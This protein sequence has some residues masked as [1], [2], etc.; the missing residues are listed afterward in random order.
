MWHKTSAAMLA[1]AS[2]CV[3]GLTACGSSSSASSEAKKQPADILADAKSALFNAKS[4]HATG[5]T[6]DS[7]TT[8]MLDFSFVGQDTSGTLTSNNVK[9]QIVKAGGTI[10]VNAPA[11]FWSKTAPTQASV[12]AG[13]WIIVPADQD[14]DFSDFTLQGI[15]ASLNSD[16]SPLQPDVKKTTVNGTKALVISQQDGSTLTVE[17]DSTPRPLKLTD[18]SSHGDV[19]FSDY[20]KVR[21]I[22]APAGAVTPQQ[23]VGA[24]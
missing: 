9:L 2:C 19:T 8:E 20:D 12:L 14:S 22:T 5:M 4:V 17:D 10:Y 21:A 18:T 15:A 6:T 1:T 13:K 7:G 16:D 24:K 11:E 23:A 3:I